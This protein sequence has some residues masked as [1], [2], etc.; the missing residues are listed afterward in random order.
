MLLTLAFL[1]FI[2]WIILLA[3]HVTVGFVHIL[4]AAAIIFAIWHFV[5]HRHTHA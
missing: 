2:A 4:I 5:G 3:V 1:F